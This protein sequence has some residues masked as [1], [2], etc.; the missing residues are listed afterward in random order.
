M[1]MIKFLTLTLIF[2]ALSQPP[3]LKAMDSAGSQ[4]DNSTTGTQS[5]SVSDDGSTSGKQ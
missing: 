1:K 3:I 4:T 2:V 5:G